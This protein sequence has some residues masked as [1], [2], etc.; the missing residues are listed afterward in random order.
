MT[1]LYAGLDLHSTACDATVINKEGEIVQHQHLETSACELVAFFS[2]F[3][4]ARL[5][6]HLEASELTG[7][8]RMVLLEHVPQIK[9]VV[10]S[11]PKSLSWIANDPLKGDRLDSWKLAEMMRMGRTH[12]VYY[13]E[14]EK[15]AVFKKT[16][17]HYMDIT[18]G[19]AALKSKIKSR[20]RTEGIIACRGVNLYSDEGR[21]LALSAIDSTFRR[22]AIGQ[23][24]TLLEHSLQCQEE[25]FR[26][27]KKQSGSSPGVFPL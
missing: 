22:D 17:Q 13:P 27:M 8:A 23:L 11:H 14:A 24:Y 7:W 9:E 20:L 26:L 5:K 25:A 4:N 16:V 12:P 10:A 19:Q 21:E 18:K 3:Q 1:V 2:S 6:L 15:L